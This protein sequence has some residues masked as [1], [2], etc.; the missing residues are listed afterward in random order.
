MASYD[1]NDATNNR[2]PGAH[3]LR[4]RNLPAAIAR[5][6]PATETTIVQ[7]IDQHTGISTF[8]ARTGYKMVAHSSNFAY[9][10]GDVRTLEDGE[11]LIHSISNIV[12]DHIPWEAEWSH[13]SFASLMAD[14]YSLTTPDF[15]NLTFVQHHIRG[16]LRATD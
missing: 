11:N 5:G 15:P 3:R 4:I 13:D 2:T 12:T 8:N 10:F 7:L 16:T 6:A 1:Y 9:A 14:T